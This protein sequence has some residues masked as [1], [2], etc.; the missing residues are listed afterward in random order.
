MIKLESWVN[1][2]ISE[3]FYKGMILDTRIVVCFWGFCTIA[4]KLLKNAIE[5]GKKN[6]IFAIVSL[7]FL[8][9]WLG[10]NV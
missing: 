10:L 1:R 4:K 2:K 6:Q 5:N 9:L 7:N 8:T 3:I